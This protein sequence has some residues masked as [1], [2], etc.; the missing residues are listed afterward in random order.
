[1]AARHGRYFIIPAAV[2]LAAAGCGE[3]DTVRIHDEA[4]P[5]RAAAPV[6]PDSQKKFRTLAAMVPV[7]LTAAEAEKTG[8]QW[9][10]IKGSGPA[11]VMARCAGD[12]DKLLESL[13]VTA[14]EKHSLA[15]DLPAGWTQGGP[16]DRGMVSVLATLKPPGGEVE[17]TLTR[18]GS[19]VLANAQR[20]WGQLWGSD[21][22]QELT[23]AI[24]PE[25]VR[26]LNVKGRLVLRVD[27]SGPNEPKRGPMMMNP[28]AGGM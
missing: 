1:M 14:D 8:G 6:I 10:F 28:H 27:M 4:A 15:W 16:E 13:R 12:F 25:Y 20:W 5:T 23:P 11:D 9:W 21:K 24:L 26:Q 2:A 19:T 7:D 22:Q 17:F 18:S 3:P